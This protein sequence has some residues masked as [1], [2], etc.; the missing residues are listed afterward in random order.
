MLAYE[1]EAQLACFE[2][3]DCLEGINAFLEKRKPQFR[4]E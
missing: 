3:Q 2:S 1:T 4:G